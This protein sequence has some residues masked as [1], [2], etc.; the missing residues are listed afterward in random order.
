MNNNLKYLPDNTEIKEYPLWYHKQGLT[1]TASGYGKKLATSKI[2]K[3]NNKWYRLYA[4][5]YSNNGTCYIISKGK[6]LILR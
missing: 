6:T 2:V 3:Y 5:I 4:C 1:Q